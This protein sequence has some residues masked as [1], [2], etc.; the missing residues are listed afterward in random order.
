MLHVIKEKPRSDIQ[1]T[2]IGFLAWESTTVK[3]WGN[4]L[5]VGISTGICYKKLSSETSAALRT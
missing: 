5:A 4:S 2:V 1:W 3:T